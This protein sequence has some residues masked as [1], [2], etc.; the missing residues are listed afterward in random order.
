M[1]SQNAFLKGSAG[2][3]THSQGMFPLW[4]QV[5]SVTIWEKSQEA[6][7]DLTQVQWDAVQGLKPGLA[8]PGKQTRF[9][10]PMGSS[11]LSVAA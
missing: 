10:E 6:L 11:L 9:L 3:V 7:L 2:G 5:G 1:V 8:S 4:G